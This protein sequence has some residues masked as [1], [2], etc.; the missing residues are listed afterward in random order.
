[1]S[2]SPKGDRRAADYFASRAL[3]LVRRRLAQALPVIVLILVGNFLLLKLAPGDAVDAYI[4]T[5][6]GGR[7]EEHTSE[8]QSH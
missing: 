1:M 2:A 4:A 6:G 3:V 5:I 8:L 7:S